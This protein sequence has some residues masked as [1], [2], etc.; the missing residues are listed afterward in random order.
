MAKPN[1]L[2]AND[3]EGQQLIDARQFLRVVKS[4]VL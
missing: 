2:L 3:I 1:A 4:A